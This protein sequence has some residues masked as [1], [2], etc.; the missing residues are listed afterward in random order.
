MH[1]TFQQLE[2]GGQQAFERT[3][4]LL[5]A[6]FWV[7][8]NTEQL[9]FVWSSYYDPPL[10]DASALTYFNLHQKPLRA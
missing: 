1:L 7:P 5:L 8:Q 2:H 10:V 6:N 9:C 4:P 3:C